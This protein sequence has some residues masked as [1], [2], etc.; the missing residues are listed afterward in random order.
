M[1]YG[2][3]AKQRHT[4][5]YTDARAPFPNCFSEKSK[6]GALHLHKFETVQQIFITASIRSN[7]RIAC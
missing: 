6:N 7:I 4:R 3:M 1:C 5:K 2:G